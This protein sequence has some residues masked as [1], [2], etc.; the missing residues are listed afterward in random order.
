[1]I[2]L[3]LPLLLISNISY[4]QVDL[5]LGL[6]AYYPFNGNANDVSGNGHNGILRNGVTFVAGK[7]NIPGSAVHF[8]G[9][10]DFIEVPNNGA[11]TASTGFSFVVQFKTEDINAVQTL[12]TR[13][14][15]S[16]QTQAQFQTFI[17][18]FLHPGFGYAHNYTNNA[19]CNTAI[20]LYNLYVNT[21]ANTIVRDRWHCVVGTFDGTV[22]RIYLDGNLMETLPTP[23]SVM[24]MCENVPM[25]FGRY[26]DLDRQTFRGTMDEIRLYNR[27]L[28]QAE[29][30]ELCQCAITS[31]NDMADCQGNSFQLNTTGGS[32][33]SWTPA[34]T[35]NNPAIANPVATP[36][37]T[38]QY[39]VTG[40]T[41]A[42]CVGNDTVNITIHPK[43]VTA[44]S[45][46]TTICI[47][48]S[49]QLSASGGISYTWSPPLSLSNPAIFNPVATPADSIL[50]YVTVTDNNT[51]SALDSVKVNV[52][53]LPVFSITPDDQICP[54]E[55]FQLTASGGN[56]Y[57][58]QPASTLSNAAIPNPVASPSTTTTYTVRVTDQGCNISSLLSTVVTVLPLPDIQAAKSN[59]IDCSND[60][61]Q[62]LASGGVQYTWTPA[63]SLSNPS[64]R[65]PVARPRTPTQYI[66]TGTDA[67]GCVN[68]D[69]VTVDVLA[70]NQSMYLVPSAFTP[71]RDG[72]NDCFGIKSW[73]IVDEFE[74]SIFNRWGERI[75]YSTNPNACWDGTYK[76]REQDP[77]VFVYMI[78]S[79]TLCSSSIFKKGTF[80][81]I[82]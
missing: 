20:V 45:N 66:V 65:N 81:L 40:T 14:K 25:T 21:G 55:T 9:N 34:S 49:A 78:R 47:G 28:N 76:G 15:R 30:L 75:F 16:D 64:V 10:D 57:D 11:L 39:I 61:S 6:V 44:T 32:I 51:C 71:N 72:L 31:N 24:D 26:T 5:A 17:N 82:R 50:Y 70:A 13:R 69:S 79:K 67:S 58:W 59:D 62:L 29:V 23:L 53:P 37:A 43:P 4:S 18:W 2:R 8:D 77:N 7:N 52:K 35:L 74:I 38:T 12:L 60:Q 3:L 36:N 68:Y 19:A 54:E 1:M 42:G 33:Y 56:I 22:Q 41:V 73:G 48:G 63:E 27:P 80:M 46:D